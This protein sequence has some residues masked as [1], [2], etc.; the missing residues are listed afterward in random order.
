M[1]PLSPEDR[2]L[3][4]LHETRWLGN[5][6][7]GENA[8]QSRW[9]RQIAPVARERENAQG[10]CPVSAV[11]TKTKRMKQVM[12]CHKA[13]LKLSGADRSD[14][15][16]VEHLKNCPAC[17]RL[18][19]AD[20]VLTNAIRSEE[21]RADFPPTS[22]PVLQARLAAQSTRKE[23]PVYGKINESHF[24]PSSPGICAGCGMLALLFFVLVPMPYQRT[25]GYNIA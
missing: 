4:T 17:S 1:R 8:G 22:F 2:A 24:G 13:R 16:L 19:S 14:P 9:H 20:D 10:D 7:T 11:E 12:R 21:T 18:A 15:E 25:T 3:V 6:R 23:L 5:R